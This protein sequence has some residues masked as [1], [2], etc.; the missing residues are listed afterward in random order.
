ME[1]RCDDVQHLTDAGAHLVL[2]NYQKRP[3]LS[4][5]RN[6][7]P[8]LTELQRHKGLLGI[9]PA[10]V[11]LWVLDVDD[12]DG[13]LIAE[14]AVTFLGDPIVTV[15][16]RSKGRLHLIYRAFDR[17][18]TTKCKWALV[19]RGILRG[20]G[21][22][23]GNQVIMWD[24]K[25]WCQAVDQRDGA[26]PV[27]LSLLP[28]PNASLAPGAIPQ[29]GSGTANDTLNKAL[30]QEKREDT[31][32][33]T[34]IEAYRTA[35][36][37]RGLTDAEVGATIASV[38]RSEPEMKQKAGRRHMDMN[39]FGLSVYE[40]SAIR[41]KAAWVASK[42]WLTRFDSTLW[43]EDPGGCH[44]THE[45]SQLISAARKEGVLKRSV[46][47]F[48][49]TR[50][51][52]AHLVDDKPWNDDPCTAG[53]PDDSV[54]DLRTGKVTKTTDNRITKRLGA[55]P[56]EGQPTR[57]LRFMKETVDDETAAWLQRWVGYTLT[58]LNDEQKFIFL[59]GA[60]ANGKSTFTRVVGR[61]LG[62]Y[63]SVVSGDSLLGPMTQ[64]RQWLAGLD[65]QRMV[66]VGE[67]PDHAKWRLGDLKDLTGEDKVAANRMRRDNVN[68][69]PVCKLFV[70][71]NVAPRV[72]VVDKAIERRLILL[73]FTREPK[74]I[75]KHLV[76][77]LTEEL[78]QILTWALEGAKQ[79]FESGLGEM[80]RSAKVATS[81]YLQQEDTVGQFLEDETEVDPDGFV[82]N[83]ELNFRATVWCEGQGLAELTPRKLKS[84]IV[85]RPGYSTGRIAK[86]R[87]I[88]GLRLREPE[89]GNVAGV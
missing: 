55:V 43:R 76:R 81:T 82:P 42:D 84:E 10:S 39:D 33:E 4:G 46:T 61:L 85:R 17:E 11:G 1:N 38:E 67:A 48:Q 9:L 77:K 53:L 29:A 47:A 86:C 16:S 74:V 28:K 63:A 25:A 20:D 66:S 75:D 14:N 40:Q 72:A 60:G 13:A 5:W 88:R 78:P 62:E 69:T 22:Y 64:H 89:N 68:F 87:G 79:Y 23:S 24:I 56:G 26:E 21:L 3:I 34:K 27:S 30:Y 80:P 2:C 41:T 70:C 32:T 18:E 31:L 15:Q 35:A 83:A 7:K 45:L 73:P 59:L 6:Q 49:L 19:E 57:W 8:T 12:V 50:D 37:E 51:M 65:G 71:A 58:G 54:L 44:V 52:R 36:I